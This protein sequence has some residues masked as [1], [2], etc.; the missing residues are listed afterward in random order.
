ML[1]VNAFTNNVSS[2]VKQAGNAIASLASSAQTKSTATAKAALAAASEKARAG[3]SF[4]NNHKLAVSAT[5]LTT[6]VAAGSAYYFQDDIAK[7]CGLGQEP[8]AAPTPKAPAQPKAA[9]KAPA[10]PKAAPK[11]PAQ[12]KAPTQPEASSEST[13]LANVSKE[14]RSM[15]DIARDT[16][17]C[18]GGLVALSNGGGYLSPLYAAPFLGQLMLVKDAVIA[19]KCLQSSL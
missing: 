8:K 11:A 13:Q 5:V 19:A 10:Q 6:I 16:A 17:I 4:V 3:A 9:P 1:Y 14:S 7:L 18:T 12:P 2:G 15:A